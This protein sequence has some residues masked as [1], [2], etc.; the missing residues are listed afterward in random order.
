V[1]TADKPWRST[2]ITSVMGPP[3]RWLTEQF[4]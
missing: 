2:L 3:S 1:T 4:A